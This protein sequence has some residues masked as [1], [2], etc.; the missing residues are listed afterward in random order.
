M[1]LRTPANR[2]SQ[3]PARIRD[4]GAAESLWVSEL[5][6]DLR[7]TRVS[8]TD[9]YRHPTLVSLAVA[10]DAGTGCRPSLRAAGSPAITRQGEHPGE[11]V[12]HPS[13]G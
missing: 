12:R 5:R 10:P 8:V 7:Y 1:R 11:R 3:G 6:K 2:P 9:A 13:S 4:S